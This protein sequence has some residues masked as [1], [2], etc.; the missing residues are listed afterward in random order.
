MH[1]I[2]PRYFDVCTTLLKMIIP[3][4][5]VIALIAMIAE[6]FISYSGEEA[7]I[8]VVFKL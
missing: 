1:L 6:Y 4:A 8:N 2:G 5:I 3:I 7:V